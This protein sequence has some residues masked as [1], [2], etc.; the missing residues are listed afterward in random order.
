MQRRSND[1]AGIVS[2]KYFDHYLTQQKLNPQDESSL[3]PIEKYKRVTKRIVN[4][5]RIFK[6]VNKEV[7]DHLKNPVYKL[8]LVTL[9]LWVYLVYFF[10]YDLIQK[11][12][13]DQTMDKFFHKYY[14][15]F[16]SNDC[17]NTDAYL[18]HKILQAFLMVWMLLVLYQIKHGILVWASTIIDFNTYNSLR[19][20]IYGALPF[21]REIMVVLSFATNKTALG[22]SHWFMIEDIKHTMTK[23]KFLIKKRESEQFGVGMGAIAKLGFQIGI[24]L[25]SVLLFVSP[26]IIF[27]DIF[28][29][30]DEYK[31]L[32]SKVKIDI[33]TNKGL[34]LN[35]LFESEMMLKTETITENNPRWDFLKHTDIWK[36]TKNNLFK[37]VR[38]SRYSQNY[39][40]YT[41][42][43]ELETSLISILTGGHIRIAI[44]FT[45][46]EDKYTKEVKIPINKAHADE[47][48]TIMETDCKLIRLNRE[49]FLENIAMVYQLET[50]KTLTEIRE[51]VAMKYVMKKW[52]LGI[53]CSYC[54]LDSQRQQ[55]LL[56]RGQRERERPRVRHRDEEQEDQ[57]RARSEDH[58]Q[59]S[60][61]EPRLTRSSCCTSSSSTTSA[62]SSSE[63]TSSTRPLTSGTRKCPNPKSCSSSSTPS[64]WPGSRWTS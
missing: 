24:V 52:S 36:R 2:K 11:S 21:F 59:Q 13:F 50:N 33:V 25:V 15:F 42:N 60:A 51:P 26:M 28:E 6:P 4:I 18:F 49:M 40:E 19:F 1:V 37:Y 48:K 7:T 61:G 10:Y 32:Y 9:C 20:S 39:Y 22:L 23:A 27:S 14:C 64:R 34:S 17:H 58:R 55:H 57:P 44:E 29:D 30:A 47:I 16:K 8:Y 12:H 41:A 62:S 53:E 45:T 31:I 56:L 38:M 54:R 46:E 43:S 35:P 5:F 3:K 63:R